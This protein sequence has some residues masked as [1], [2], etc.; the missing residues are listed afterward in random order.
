MT[1]VFQIVDGNR[2]SDS[3]LRGRITA[4]LTS[5]FTGVP[6]WLCRNQPLDKE[7]AHGELLLDTAAGLWPDL[8]AFPAFHDGQGE[9]LRSYLEFKELEG[10]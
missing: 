6:D 9:R 3:E 4:Y 1:V 2:C 5:A 10:Q 8:T 7:S